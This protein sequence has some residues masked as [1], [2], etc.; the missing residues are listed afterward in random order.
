MSEENVEA[1]GG[2]RT[3]VS[4]RSETRRRSL[5]QQILVRFPALTRVLLSAWSR[6][7]P[8]SRLRRALL[9][10]IIGQVCEAANR[11]D[12][13]L[14]FVFFDPEIELEL[15][16]SPLGALIP[17]DLPSVN[18]GH[19]AYRRVWEAMIEAMADFRIELDEVVDFGERLLTPA[20][21]M[22]RG[23]A[24]GAPVTQLVAQ[25][26]TLRRGLVIRQEDF[27]D[28]DKALEAAGL[29]E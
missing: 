6:L 15:E 20:R 13:E 9:A 11:R 26:I 24:S 18:R 27:T 12:F 25:V 16:D 14:L 29:S 3:P 17:P 7:P 8:R 10:R 1:V 23:S 22:G 21:F 4:V 2:V 19:D 5:D 28:R